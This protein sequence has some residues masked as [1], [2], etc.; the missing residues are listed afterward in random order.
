MYVVQKYRWN[1]IK[2]GI[3]QEDRSTEAAS[4]T[5]WLDGVV[6]QKKTLY[7]VTSDERATVLDIWYNTLAVTAGSQWR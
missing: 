1:P 3:V 5:T 4:G 6:F 2:G 7:L